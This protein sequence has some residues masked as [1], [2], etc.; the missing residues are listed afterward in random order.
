MPIQQPRYVFPYPP[1]DC[2]PELEDNANEHTI[3]IYAPVAF[4]QSFNKAS[5]VTGLYSM[6]RV[7]NFLEGR[8]DAKPVTVEPDERL[9]NLIPYPVTLTSTAF[10]RLQ[11][12]ARLRQI[13]LLRLI[14]DRIGCVIREKHVEKDQT[15]YNDR[16]QKRSDL[17]DCGSYFRGSDTTCPR[18][19]PC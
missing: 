6:N 10:F 16:G 19:G 3:H 15:E 4:W 8:T 1:E 12:E 11:D 13:T 5:K 7:Q 9:I 2:Y 18:C 17:C 14:L